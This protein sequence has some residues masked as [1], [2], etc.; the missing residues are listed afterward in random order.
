[1]RWNPSGET[2]FSAT[3]GARIGWVNATWPLARLVV[4]PSLLR[5]SAIQGAYDFL[6]SQVVS[7]QRY[8]SIPLFSS[9]V[10]IVHAHP[11]YPH[12]IVF[13]YFG[14]SEKLI[15]KIRQAGF[16]PTAPAAAEVK[17]RGIP[18]RW[19]A[20]LVFILVWYGLFLP[21]RAF[22]KPP[23]AVALIPVITTFFV[24]CGIKRYPWLQKAILRNGHSIGEIKAY[25]SLLQTVTGFLSVIFL[26]LALAQVF[27]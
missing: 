5:L 21:M 2:V 3:G 15:E 23:L 16:L 27:G 10:R 19:T 25:L 13:W 26:V 11:D 20:I 6:P 17:W 4:S 1:M 12:K 18:V 9:G 8:G 7:L 22:A 14:N 24:C